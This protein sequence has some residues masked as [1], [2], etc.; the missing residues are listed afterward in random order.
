MDVQVGLLKDMPNPNLEF[1]GIGSS[2]VRGGIVDK[3]VVKQAVIDVDAVYHLAINWNG[4]TWRHM[5]PLADL[6]D[7]NIRGTLNLLE[8][9]KSQGVK[10]FLFS[11]SCAVYG[12]T[13]SP[14]QDEESVC[15]PESWHGDPGPAYGILKLTT[16]KLCLMY[17]HH[18]ELPTTAFRLGVVY[19]DNETLFLNQDTI[20][21][22]TKGETIEVLEGDGFGTV[23]VGEVVE[24]FLT[25]TL[26]KRAYGHVFNL[27]NPSTYM[28]YA[29]LY[30]LIKEATGS[31]TQ[32]R[33]TKAP[34]R[35]GSAP[36][37]IEKIQKTL[38]LKPQKTK[39]DIK[40]AIKKHVHSIARA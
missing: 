6:F 29:E 20:N 35:P 7:A 21:M 26:N 3:A 40:E 13:E 28:T 25:A 30:G 34:T 39:E 38:G 10:H 19:D 17:N 18:Y 24:A 4:H 1:L 14:N 23:H 37:S 31:K 36:E 11:S 33:I 12:E 22:V 8:A 2:D 9:A 5:L 27:S 15:K 16:E 32:I